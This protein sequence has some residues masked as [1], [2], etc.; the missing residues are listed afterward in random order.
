MSPFVSQRFVTIAAP[1]HGEDVAE[2]RRLVED[3]GLR[4]SV[5]ATYPLDG[6]GRAIDDLAAGRIHGKAVVIP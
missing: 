5:G 3:E 6:V 1:N 2:L 4:S